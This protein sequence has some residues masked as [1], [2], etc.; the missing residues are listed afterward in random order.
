MSCVPV[1][2]FALPLIFTLVA[3]SISHFLSVAI[4]FH[5]FIIF[6]KIHL[7]CFQ[8]LPNSSSFSAILASVDIEI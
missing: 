8:S 2:S 5:A 7:F 6:I 1:R 3:A 4:K